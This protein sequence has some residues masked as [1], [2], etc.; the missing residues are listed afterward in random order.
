[1]TARS[2]KIFV[3]LVV[4]DL[5]ASKAFFGKLGFEFNPQFSDDNAACM[6]L[7]EDGYV[8]LMHASQWTRFSTKKP[9][10]TSTQNEA[11]LALSCESRA[12]VDQLVKIA[13]ASGGKH[14]MDS[15]DHGFMYGWSFYDLDGHHW[16]VIWMDPS[17]VQK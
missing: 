9:C 6:V 15:Q 4:A 7:S 1:V 5:P 13:I 12:E 8:M 16:E 17:F 10:D 11:L 2:R 3:N 14:A